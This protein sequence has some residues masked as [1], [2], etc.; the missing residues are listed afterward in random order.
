MQANKLVVIGNKLKSANS[1]FES[2]EKSLE[3]E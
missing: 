3:K 1:F 2:K